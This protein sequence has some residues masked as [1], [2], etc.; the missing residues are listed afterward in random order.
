MSR[1]SQPIRLIDAIMTI[2]KIFC[3]SCGHIG[4]CGYDEYEAAHFFHK[5][6]WREKKDKIY[7]PHCLKPK[8]EDENS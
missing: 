4:E 6:G 5:L 3:D 2:S 8:T 1:E 7:C